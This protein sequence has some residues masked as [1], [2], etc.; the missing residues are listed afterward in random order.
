MARLAD[1]Y[2]EAATL[3]P[4]EA[5]EALG[6]VGEPDEVRERL[7]AYLDAG[8]TLPI[9]VEVPSQDTLELLKAGLP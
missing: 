4:D 6:C 2:A 7:R 3:V 8:V 9:L 5:V 1:E